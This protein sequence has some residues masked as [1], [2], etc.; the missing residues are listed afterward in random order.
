VGGKALG[1]DFKLWK[2]IADNSVEEV[3]VDVPSAKHFDGGAGASKHKL[4]HHTRCTALMDPD[5]ER[6]N[7]GVGEYV[8]FYFDPPVVMTPPE[9]PH[10]ETTAGSVD[11]TTGT[12]RLFTAPSNGV[13]A[14]VKVTVRDAKL[15]TAFEVKEPSGVDHA[16]VRRTENLDGVICAAGAYLTVYIAPTSVSFS[17]VELGEI[18]RYA[19]DVSGR[20]AYFLPPNGPYSEED[21]K[22]DAYGFK[23]ISCDNRW[24]PDAPYD[25]GGDHI[26]TAMIPPLWKGSYTWPIPAQWRIPGVEARP[27]N[28]WSPQVVTVDDNSNARITKFGIWVERSPNGVYTIGP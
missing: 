1:S 12:G 6:Q 23:P 17:R 14:T 9:T 20:Y 25:E 8:D 22:H 18:A 21:L 11:P 7:L 26:R 2:V 28:N 4:I 27:L 5:P 13:P 10:W 16:V 15:A 24:N 3:T 19:T